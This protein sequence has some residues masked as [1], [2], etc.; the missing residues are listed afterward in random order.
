MLASKQGWENMTFRTFVAIFFALPALACG[1]ALCFRSLT[2]AE[3]EQVA[4]QNNNDIKTLQQ[5]VAKSRQGR[6][7]AVSKWFPEIVLISSGYKTE[8]RQAFT[9]THSAFLSQFNVTQ[10]LLSTERYFNLRIST[11]VV[12][13][14]NFLLDAIVIDVLFD[15]RQAYYKVILDLQDINTA[16]TSVGRTKVVRILS[17]PGVKRSSS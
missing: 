10:A 1:E 15:V 11:L 6:L 9:G 8:K 12:Q 14:L 2:L 3:A 17:G 5:L 4:I 13:Q 16:K 7:E